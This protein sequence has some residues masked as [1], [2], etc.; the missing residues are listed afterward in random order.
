MTSTHRGT[1]FEAAFRGSPPRQNTDSIVLLKWHVIIWLVLM[2]ETGN[3][4]HADALAVTVQWHV[5]VQ[6]QVTWRQ[7]SSFLINIL[8]RSSPIRSRFRE[9]ATVYVVDQPV[10]LKLS[11]VT[12]VTKVS[13]SVDAVSARDSIHDVNTCMHNSPVSADCS[14]PATVVCKLVTS[15]QLPS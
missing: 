8:P 13:S 3:L 7:T 14:K 12:I 10:D 6:V 4:P 15:S 11:R 1:P 9:H 2:R 5:D